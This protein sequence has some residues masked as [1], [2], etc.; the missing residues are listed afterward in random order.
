MNKWLALS[1]RNKWLAFRDKRC[2]RLG[3]R[4]LEFTGVWINV[5]RCVLHLLGLG[6]IVSVRWGQTVGVIVG[7]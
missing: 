6:L 4:G 3:K 1:L 7:V 2:R 5:L